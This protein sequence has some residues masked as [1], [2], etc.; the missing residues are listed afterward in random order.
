LRKAQIDK[1]ELSEI[2][3]LNIS[4]LI[5]EEEALVL[6]LS[7]FRA[8][9]HQSTKEDE[10]HVLTRYLIELAKAFNRFYYQLPVLQ[11]TNKDQKLLRL[12]LVLAVK[13]TLTNG[14][15]LLGVDCPEEM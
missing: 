13:Q 15:L 10:P 14:F 7:R 5:L 2:S 4:E 8:M 11:A 12:S 9:L 6:S 3:A 1:I